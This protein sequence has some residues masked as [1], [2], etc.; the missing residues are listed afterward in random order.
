VFLPAC[1]WVENAGVFTPKTA[2]P[3]TVAGVKTLT[4][5]TY[6]DGLFKRLRG[7]MGN[8]VFTFIAG[9]KVMVAFTFTG[10]WDDPSDVAILTPTY[11][12]TKPPR[13][14]NSGFSIGGSG[15]W[16]PKLEQ[17]TIDLGNEVVLREDP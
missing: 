14:A 12:T 11:P 3:G 17:L 5:G 1:G 4:I 15:G 13:F 10:I 16:E 8:A 2:P 7:C 6:E 9:Q